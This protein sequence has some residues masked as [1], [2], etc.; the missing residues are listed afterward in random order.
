LTI[1]PFSNGAAI[2]KTL[3]WTCWASVQSFYPASGLERI[4]SMDATTFTAR[5]EPRPRGGGIAIRIPYD[6]VSAW[7]AR[8]RYDMTGTV[9]GRKV[10]GRLVERNGAYFLEL[11]PAWCR[12]NSLADQPEVQVVL[13]PEGPQVA[14]MP[15][16]LSEAL[17]AS[18]E[19][20]QYFESLATFYRKGFMRWIDSAKLP[21]TRARRI[22]ETVAA[23]KAGKREP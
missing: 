19:A 15:P 3:G 1:P 13:V 14:T 6:P 7:G 11:G 9:A 17:N 2:W 12:D 23:L 4:L 8:G 10:R 5:P 21:E 18:P 22:S 20:R 16:D